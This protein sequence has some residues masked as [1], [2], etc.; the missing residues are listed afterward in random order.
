MP[1][2]ISRQEAIKQGLKHYFTGKPCK[3]NG[4]LSIRL[5]SNK[6]CYECS[7]LNQ[8][9]YFKNN[10][11]YRQRKKKEKERYLQ[12]L[13]DNPDKME[14]Y[15]L[16]QLKWRTSEHG[17]KMRKKYMDKY[18]KQPEV[19]KRMKETSLE[20][21]KS[22]HGK[23]KRKKYMD[24][25]IK[26]PEVQKRMKETSDKLRKSDEG[27]AQRNAWMK[28][29]Y[30]NPIKHLEYNMRSR[31]NKIMTGKQRVKTKHTF[32]LIGCTSEELKAHIEKQFE[33]KMTWKNYGK[34]HVD[35][36]IPLAHFEKHFDMNEVYNQKIAFNF[37]NLQPMWAEENLK[38]KDKISKQVADKKI[39]E[40]KKIIL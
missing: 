14:K 31:V 17:K 10:D 20:Y 24:E 25:Y 22:E 37:N 33:K 28:N 4:H 8:K 21:R 30:K 23:S 32:E 13:K 16:S 39:A 27:R 2:V 36:I 12:S 1:K 26:Q 29:S 34:W 3:R 6:G 15:K 11:A 18:I 19:E 5:V 7:L 38:K 9:K 40:I 35:H